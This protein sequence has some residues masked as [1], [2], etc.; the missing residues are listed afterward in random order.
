VKYVVLLAYEPSVWTKAGEETRERYHQ[1]HLA[2]HQAAQARATLVAGEAL[3]GVDT[4]TTMRHR[5]GG[6]K[7]TDGPFAETV[8]QIGG[9]Y[10]VD[11]ESLDVMTDLCSMLPSPYAVEIRPVVDVEGFD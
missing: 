3:A 7:L 9:F 5:D 11:A 10:L 8:E 2:F 4:A 1:A 6:W